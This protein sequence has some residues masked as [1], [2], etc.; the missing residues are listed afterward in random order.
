MA[1]HRRRRLWDPAGVH[2]RRLRGGDGDRA[3]PAELPCP[4]SCL[5][6]ARA[7]RNAGDV[8][9][10]A[11]GVVA[12]GRSQRCRAAHAARDVRADAP[13][14]L[15]FSRASRRSPRRG[16]W[17]RPGGLTTD[18][19]SARWRH[20]SKS[21]TPGRCSHDGHP[22]TRSAASS[23]PGLRPARCSRSTYFRHTLS[24]ISAG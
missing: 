19:S 17:R 3:G 9:G 4:R 2:D 1:D 6:G 23:R 14:V 24:G 20:T 18:A 10:G 21:V 12:R 16:G 22:I 7:C 11:R 15:S 5:R 13:V 8:G